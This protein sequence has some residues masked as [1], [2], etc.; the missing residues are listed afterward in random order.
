M[1]TG[2]QNDELASF[3]YLRFTKYL[4]FFLISGSSR[5]VKAQIVWSLYSLI[6][7]EIPTLHGSIFPGP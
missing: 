1:G 7:S 3:L 6:K 2:P 4:H 5:R